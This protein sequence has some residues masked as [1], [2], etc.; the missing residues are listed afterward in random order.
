VKKYYYSACLL[1]C[2]LCTLPSYAQKEGQQLIDSLVRELPNSKEDTGK[3]KLLN[4]LSN[5]YR[6]VNPYEG[7]RY[8]QEALDLAE[9]LEWKQGIAGAYSSLGY[10]YQYRSEY[11]A[12]LD[13]FM[14]AMK[15]DEEIG[16]KRGVANTMQ[17]L[18]NVY[19]YQ[20]N[21]PKVLEYQLNAQKIFEQLGD[22]HGAAT[23]LGNIGIYYFSQ[24]DYD[25]A[26]E[27]DYKALKIAEDENYQN[28]IAGNLG[29]I[30]DAYLHKKE[31][32]KS[33]E[34]SFRS[35]RIFES[36][37]DKYG[38]AI[39]LGNI[40]ETYL[41][42]AQ[43]NNNVQP[44]SLIPAGKS[45]NLKKAIEYLELSIAESRKISQLDN[46]I[47]FSEYLSDAYKLSGNYKAAL[48]SYVVY[49]KTND[50][51]YS[52]QN[53]QQIKLLENKQALDLKDR[54]LQ[55]AKLGLSKERNERVFLIG[56]IVALLVV[57]AIVL[58][59]YNLQKRSNRLLTT[60]MKRSDDL[61]L[62]ILPH[63]VAN[64]L[65]EKGTAAARYFD[66]VTVIFTDFV[67]FTKAGER[68]SPQE[69]IDEL[70]TC[71]K[72]FDEIIGK[73]H[74][75]KIKTIGDAYLAVSGLPVSDPA[76]AQN[77]LKAATEI[78]SYM[79]KRKEQIGDKTFGIRIGIH[80]GSVVAGIV[81][82]KKFAYDIWG[83]AVNTAARMEQN[84][85]PG[86]I[87]ISQTTYELVK[88]NFTCTYRG[89]IQAKN[90]G[91]MSMYFVE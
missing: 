41:A 80:S 20:K 5:V 90:K 24:H 13:Y 10:N 87:N 44:D 52:L 58:R 18:A 21:Y 56:G 55:I 76:H 77:A 14:K 12:A 68:M 19:Q 53:S 51:V 61:L 84:S 29:N 63:E 48:E 83:D 34:C 91:E 69:L 70:H 62:N 8:G 47:E 39:D 46:I 40:G 57:I 89:E 50:S 79:K 1:L 64:E 71:F 49:A 17:S 35:I 43:D 45:A 82:V 32:S 73:Y 11:P 36:L 3:V 66:N 72:E 26:L 88:D 9:Q 27:Y 31:Y 16:N 54:D 81:G 37:G 15:I 6:L 23:N 67:N 38:T 60:E 2:V 42:I 25:K 85:E 33:L 59:N 7:I 65:K 30:G 86:K 75:E 22:K 74:I 4:A 78:R 28:S